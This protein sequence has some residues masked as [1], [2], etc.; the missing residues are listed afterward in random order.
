MGSHSQNHQDIDNL[1][2][3]CQRLMG[4]QQTAKE[5]LID[6][7]IGSLPFPTKNPSGQSAPDVLP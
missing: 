2:K 3:Q 5:T 7:S 6:P 1:S 4:K